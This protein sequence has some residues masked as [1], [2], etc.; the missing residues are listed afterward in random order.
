MENYTPEDN[1]SRIAAIQS[2]ISCIVQAPA[3]SGKTELLV[4]RFLNLLACVKE[5]EEILAITFTNKA[6]A[7]MKQRVLRYLKEN[8]N[9]LSADIRS[10][11]LS[12]RKRRNRLFWVR[13]E[14]PPAQAPR[15]FIRRRKTVTSGHQ[16]ASRPLM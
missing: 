1:V 9:S 3:G 15:L 12:V 8:D 6:A 7:E 14:P 5:P 2:N 4:R 13:V 10:L 16:S 11:V